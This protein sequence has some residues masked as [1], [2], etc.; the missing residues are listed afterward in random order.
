MPATRK[1]QTATSN[2]EQ[3]IESMLSQLRQKLPDLNSTYGVRSIGL[4]GS[5]VDG[6]HRPDSDLDVLVELGDKPIGLFAY[7]RLQNEL[8]DLLG[9]KVDL[10]DKRGLKPRIGQRILA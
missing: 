1:K 4:F 7:V 6:T 9:L 8:S 5:R 2:G 3:P 10:V